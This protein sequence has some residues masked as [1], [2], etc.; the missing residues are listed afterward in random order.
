M[1]VLTFSEDEP[2]AEWAIGVREEARALFVSVQR[3]LVEMA[4][5][6]G[7]YEGAIRRCLRILERD[8]YDE[9][10]HLRLVGTS[11][12]AGHHGEARRYYR[13]YVKRMEDL[14]VEPVPYPADRTQ[15]GEGSGTET[16]GTAE[17]L[18]T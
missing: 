7:E 13:L 14:S 17:V 4:S 11:A 18:E 3:A 10:A 16:V 15:G 2:Y 5:G 9:D 1:P 12:A 6:R 8:P